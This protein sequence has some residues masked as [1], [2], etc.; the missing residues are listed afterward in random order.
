MVRPDH[1][2]YVLTEF[3]GAFKPLVTHVTGRW[4]F[5]PAGTGTRV[6]WSW[7]LHPTNA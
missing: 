2:D 1:F 5:A 6:T 3:T 4:A 7:T